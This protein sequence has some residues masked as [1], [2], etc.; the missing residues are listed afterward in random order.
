MKIERDWKEFWVDDMGL[1]VALSGEARFE[2][3]RKFKALMQRLT[4][5][6]QRELGDCLRQR[7]TPSNGDSGC[8]EATSSVKEV[9]A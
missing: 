2:R 4:E 5:A 3:L 8:Q 7:F 1:I 9:T 6:E